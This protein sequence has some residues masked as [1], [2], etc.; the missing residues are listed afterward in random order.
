MNKKYQVNKKNI[1]NPFHFSTS[2]LGL[3][4]LLVACAIVL[5]TAPSMATAEDV[6]TDIINFSLT[7]MGSDAQGKIVELNSFK[8]NNMVMTFWSPGC[9]HCLHELEMLDKLSSL[10]PPMLNIKFVLITYDYSA[11]KESMP[12]EVRNVITSMEKK[13]HVLGATDDAVFSAYHISGVP[14][15]FFFNNG[16]LVGEVSGAMEMESLREKALEYFGVNLY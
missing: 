4:F 8:D 11:Q 12:E 14:H 1:V 9:P 7:Q 6:E 3:F 10:M 2:L 5:N 13:Y 15:N 16:K